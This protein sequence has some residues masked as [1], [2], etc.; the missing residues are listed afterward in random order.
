VNQTCRFGENYSA[1]DGSVTLGELTPGEYTLL[2]A[3]EYSPYGIQWVG[4]KGGTGSQYKAKRLDVVA[5]QSL[6]A[7]VVRLDPAASITGTITDAQTGEPLTNGCAAVLPWR[8]GGSSNVVGPYCSS[9]DSGGQYTIANLGPYDWPVQF[10][11][12]YSTTET[13]ASNWSGNATDRKS[14]TL[15]PAGLDRPTVLDGALR[16]AGPGMTITAKTADGQ[17]YNGDLTVDVFNARTGDFVKELSYQR[18]L[19]GVA[20]QP[21]RLQYFTAGAFADSWYGGANFATASNVRV[22]P[23]NPTTVKLTLL[24]R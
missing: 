6:A 23:D 11:Y 17:P 16:K 3:P 5:G 21:V 13:Y 24:E 9:Y 8:P 12:F 18:T 14:A 4:A 10:S 2:A 15:V 7:P 20:E 19:D 1:A 22:R